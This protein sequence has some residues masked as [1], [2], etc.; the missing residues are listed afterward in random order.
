MT[1]D[2][3]HHSIPVITS[4]YRHL[5]LI[6]I[7][8]VLALLVTL[9]VFSVWDCYRDYQNVIKSIELETKSYA[10]ALKEHAERAFS[11]IDLV[12]QTTIQQINEEGGLNRFNKNKLDK[13]VKILTTGTPQ[14]GSL[15]I[16]D[17]TGRFVYISIPNSDVLPNVSECQFFQHHRNSSSPDLFISPP[18]KSRVTGKWR[19]SLSR[20][21]STPSGAFAGLVMAT[22]ELSYFESLYQSIVSDR[23]G[24]FSLVSTA[25]N[26]LVLVPSTEAVYQ[27]AKKTAAS[28]RKMVEATP[29]QTYHN[30]H[31]NIA[32]EY[33]IVSYCRLDKYPVIAI[34]SFVREQAVAEWRSSTINR[35]LII[36]VLCLLIIILTR[37]LLLQLKQLDQKEQKRTSQLSLSNTLLKNEIRDR[38]QIEE[39]LLAHQHTMEK[40]AIELSLAEDK[41]RSRIAGELHDQ[42][43]QRL[44]L[45]K[46]KLDGLAVTSTN[47]ESLQTAAELEGL[48]EQSIQDIRTLTFQLRPPMLA[49]AGLLPA[50]QW[51]GAE[52]ERDYGLLV[53][54]KLE[55]YTTSVKH[56]RYEIRPILFY[57]T[58]ELLL[59]VIKHTG[60]NTA[61]L[62][63]KRT[64]DLLE[65]SVTD[66][67]AGFSV[68]QTTETKSDKGGFGLYNL[69]QKLEY[70][71][72]KLS[73]TS[74]LGKGTCATI[75]LPL[76]EGLL[77]E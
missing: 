31:S 24:R 13:Q 41:E 48:V 43:G 52:L 7:S 61:L 38:R 60:T 2:Q 37:L 17:A 45:C 21:I 58:R 72:G 30:N 68:G 15:S 36:S 74:Q 67:G 25:G 18:F 29:A 76:H 59:N 54:I 12:L 8:S 10:R 62:V 4:N 63:I 69:H 5:R 9:I 33:R 57:A 22:I 1:A 27:T 70:L 28:F 71:G 66:T 23:N 40:M 75:S 65:I 32:K 53:E 56:L 73:I 46:I 42:L 51:L 3:E 50:L 55:Q 14:I 19:F 64:A 34:A 16:I 49:T 77:E 11:E 6:I 20:R 26:H 39:N 47:K 44:I 35:G